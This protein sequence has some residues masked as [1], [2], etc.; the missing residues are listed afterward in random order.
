MKAKPKEPKDP[1]LHMN[2]GAFD[3]I[4]RGALQ[5]APVKV[6]T[7]VRYAD[8]LADPTLNG[9]I[10]ILFLGTHKEYDAVDVDDL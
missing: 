3:Q 1:E 4:M 9:M 2:A 5:V 6:V 8:L 7:R 10:F